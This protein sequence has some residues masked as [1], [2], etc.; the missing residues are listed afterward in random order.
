M[1]QKE[2]DDR[3]DTVDDRWG[4]SNGGNRMCK[5]EKKE[6]GLSADL[7]FVETIVFPGN[8]FKLYEKC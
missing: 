4:E 5:K 3:E 6:K 1:L 2:E 8:T 7:P